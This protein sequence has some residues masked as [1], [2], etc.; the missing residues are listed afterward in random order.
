MGRGASKAGRSSGAKQNP[1]AKYENMSESPAYVTDIK[2]GDTLSG[3]VVNESTGQNERSKWTMDNGAV[4]MKNV[5]MLSDIKVTSVKVSGKT[6]KIVG[7]ATSSGYTVSKTFKNGA[8]VQKRKP[9][10]T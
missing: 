3:R 6:T 5:E 1:L 8:I 2:V 10:N 9:Y 4:V 7:T